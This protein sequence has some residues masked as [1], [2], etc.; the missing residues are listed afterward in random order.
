MP[1]KPPVGEAL[2]CEL[3]EVD[4]K[5]LKALQKFELSEFLEQNDEKRISV[6]QVMV[7]RVYAVVRPALL[8]QALQGTRPGEENPLCVFGSEG[9]GSGVFVL[10]RPHTAVAVLSNPRWGIDSSAVMIWRAPGTFVFVFVF[11]F[12]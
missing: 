5:V 6:L 8:A 3:L 10:P 4:P 1:D 12:S 11:V 7:G 2:C 9:T